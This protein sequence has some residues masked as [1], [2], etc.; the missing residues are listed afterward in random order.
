[1]G[2]ARH[3]CY[4]LNAATRREEEIEER[5]PGVN[6]FLG[7]GIRL[8]VPRFVHWERVPGNNNNVNAAQGRSR[9]FPAPP[10]PNI[11]RQP[12]SQP[13]CLTAGFGYVAPS[14]QFQPRLN[15]LPPCVN[16][17]C[18]CHLS[19]LHPLPRIKLILKVPPQDLILRMVTPLMPMAA[20]LKLFLLIHIFSYYFSLF[21]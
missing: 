6:P 17:P 13:C 10:Q 16:L 20:V 21:S 11:R 4:V 8:V 3:L 5:R 18:P 9:S 1:M 14:A 12:H 7:R 2:R 19:P 15:P